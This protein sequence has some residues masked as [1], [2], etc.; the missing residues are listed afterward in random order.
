MITCLDLE[1]NS[2][3]LHEETVRP[4]GKCALSR[5][6]YAAASRWLSPHLDYS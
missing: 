3:P 6:T 2:E 4:E 1:D 5:L